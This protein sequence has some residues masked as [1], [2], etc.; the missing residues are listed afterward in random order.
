MI[1]YILVIFSLLY[2][3]SCQDTNVL[4]MTDAAADAVSAITLTDEDVRKLAERSAHASDSKFQ[5]ALI[6]NPYEA[7]LR[8][9]LEDYPQRD[10]HTFNVKVYLTKD[11][12]AFA[13]A[14]GTIR[15]YSGLMDLMND[16]ELLFVI[17]HEM[18]HV[19]KKHSR[20]KVVVTYASSALRKGLAS[21]NNE[22]GQIARSVLGAFAE[23]LTNAQFSQH[24]ER[25]ADLYG[26][27]FLQEEGYEISAAISALEKL[28]V[29]AEQHTF[30]SSHPNPKA[31][32]KLLLQGGDS[33]GE[34][35]SSILARLL[36]HGKIIVIGLI[37]LVLSLVNW[38]ISLW[39]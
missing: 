31:R 38:F 11:V 14:D 33:E 9:L 24:E 2:L 26:A 37:N 32:A 3:S 7:R 25:Q 8:K 27:S 4:V 21:Q 36:E 10:G 18:G 35:Q 20:K 16:E 23:Q 6:G 22:V 13:M 34:D 15:I 28:A 12:N 39:S 1:R 17:G 5:L 19:V 29:L 30:L